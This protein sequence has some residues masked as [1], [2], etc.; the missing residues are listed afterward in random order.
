[1][2]TITP[3]LIIKVCLLLLSMLFIVQPPLHAQERT[4]Q[5][6]QNQATQTKQLLILTKRIEPFV[7]HE[8][9]TFSGFSIDLWQMIAQ[10]LNWNFTFK[11]EP[12]LKDLLINIEKHRG[13]VAIAAVT[14]TAD[15]EKVIDFSHPFF[16]SG[17]AIM[18]TNKA[19]SVTDQIVEVMRAM[20]LT[21]T[22]ALAGLFLLI[23]LLIVSHVI[24]L[25]ERRNNSQFSKSYVAGIWDSFW[26][27][28]VTI[29][30]VGYGDKAPKA[31][32]GRLFAM[33]W[34][35]VGYFMFA[36][37]TAS[38]TSSVTI[39]ELRGSINGPDDLPGHR[40]AVI[41]KSTSDK[42]ITRFESRVKIVRVDQIEQAYKL[43]NS[44]AIDAIIH[45][46]PVLLY[47]ANRDGLGKIK[48]A[49]AVFKE[50]DY[51]IV[52]PKGSALREPINQALLN[53]VENGEYAKLYRKWFGQ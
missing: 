44:N 31:V 42:Y 21:R 11:L 39:R 50:E 6:I 30:T 47:Y 51:G 26:W 23:T 15:R 16:R 19:S 41:T 46:A 22:F 29:T 5:Q 27:A 1:M 25:L 24:W 3:K 13:D 49:G 18:T 20:F 4:Q 37:F 32:F 14:I 34:M 2:I 38:V 52:L 48:I 28:L 40:V 17:L 12:T 45:D 36:Y 7:S 35:I 9:G 33:V 8:D 53:L 10:Q 43:L